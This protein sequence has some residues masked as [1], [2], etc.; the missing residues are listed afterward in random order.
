M[1]L[2]FILNEFGQILF[3]T[4][5]NE[6]VVSLNLSEGGLFLGCFWRFSVCS[7]THEV[8]QILWVFIKFW[9]GF[10]VTWAYRT[11][12]FSS[13][14]YVSVVFFFTVCSHT[15]I[16][17]YIKPLPLDVF[18]IVCFG[19][20]EG[21]FPSQH[22]NQEIHTQFNSCLAF[23]FMHAFVQ[24]DLHCIHAFAQNQSW[25]LYSYTIAAQFW[26]LNQW[27]AVWGL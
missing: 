22:C 5:Q 6:A 17:S 26:V 2:C 14:R 1:R 7:L 12:P 11:T 15:M 23:K 19:P 18:Q 8:L 20:L 3:V 16:A 9:R 4:K 21:S 25:D 13:S 24:S 27:M 10:G